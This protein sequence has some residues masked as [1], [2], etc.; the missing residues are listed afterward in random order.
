MVAV[1]SKQLPSPNEGDDVKS[2]MCVSQLM[3]SERKQHRFGNT[4]AVAAAAVEQHLM[5]TTN[6]PQTN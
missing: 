1:D 2:M 5:I 6:P 3:V 4:Y